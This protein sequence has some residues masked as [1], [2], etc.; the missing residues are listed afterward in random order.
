MI[1]E[2]LK[3]EELSEVLEL[4]KT[5]IPFEILFDRSIE[6]YREMLMDENYF[7]LV[8]KED[9][10][11]IGSALGICCKCLAVSFLVIEDVIVKDGVRG[12]GVG[13]K[14]MESLDEFAKRKHCAYALLVSSAF[15]KEAHR[16]YE[17]AGFTDSVRGFRKVY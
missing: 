5:L 9:N 4:H 1:I 14:L 3:I 11:V 10:K 17:K 8:A 12:K 7:L 13:K 16:F 2:K 15:R 6:I